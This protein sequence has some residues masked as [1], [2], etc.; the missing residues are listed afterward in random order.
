M[1]QKLSLAAL[2]LVSLSNVYGQIS[3][4]S[5]SATT[6]WNTSRWNNSADGPLY[7]ST[8]T[9]NNAVSFT[10]GT[11]S[12]AGMGA[13]INVG[14]VT[15]ASGVS[16]SFATTGS[17]YATGGLVRTINVGAGGLFDLNGNA[18]STATG[19]G[20]IKSG[21][22]VFGTGGG[23]F[24][25]GFTL[26]AGT[27]I[28][29]GTT[30]LGSGATNT[31]AL[32]GGTLASNNSRDFVNTRF[33][34]GI[35]IGGDVQFGELA[36][37]VS[38]AGSS[39]DLSFANNVSLGNSN[40]ILTLG[41]NGIQT[42]SGVI[43]NT[44]TGGI[45][46]AA[47]AN[48]GG[49]FAITSTSNSFS[50]PV[51]ISGGE[52]RFS[53]ADSFGNANNDIVVD[54]G[55][56]S[57]ASASSYTIA[58]T[59]GIQLG[60]AP[61]SAIS[62]TTSGTLT[63]NGSVINKS[64]S[65]GILVKEGAGVLSLGGSNSYTGATLI[66]GGTLALGASGSIDN[67]SEVSLGSAGTFDVSAKVGGYTVGTLRGSGNVTGALSV[68]TQLAIGNSAGGANFSS[69]LAIGSGATYLYE[70]TGGA[71]PGA[72]S[73][74]LGD[75]AGALTL[76]AGAILDLVQLGNYTAGNKFTLFAYDGTLSGTFRNAT[77]I[78]LAD[79]DTFTDAGGI[80][81]ILYADTSPGSNGGVSTTNTYVTIT[82]IP[83]PEAATLVGGL[84]VLG[85]LR[86][87]R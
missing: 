6:A 15:V 37:V 87:R 9:A 16:V 63:Y 38:I 85:L 19:T 14:D 82:A 27:V 61:G 8:Y 17:T 2:V 23:A 45:T 78:V 11:Y 35:T 70:L 43:S 32:N 44:G 5:T 53:G 13:T 55:R 67:T 65:T 57:T 42:L 71:T 26:N 7:T 77:L 1:K 80:W 20:L 56:L 52:A 76:S 69:S 48:T 51:K 39:A 36:T 74:D 18:V 49:R 22:G 46:F 28:A 24:T 34:G 54:G 58:S 73:A 66:S 59:H 21:D 60:A 4:T 29:R 3:Y 72:G 31:L 47:N 83:E 40:R 68:S 84:G 41:N 79:G 33:G 25:G 12:F 62:V 81:K 50:G 10:S 86:R 64:G 30:G 75:V